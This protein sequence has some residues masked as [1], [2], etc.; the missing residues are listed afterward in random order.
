MV[1]EL[2][3][4]SHE[5]Q[6]DEAVLRRLTGWALRFSPLV[7][8]VAP[9]TLLLDITGCQ[10]LFGGEENI[11]RQ[12]VAGLARHGFHARAAIA[13]TIG[14][15]YA[16]ASAGRELLPVVPAGQA[17][18]YLAPLPPHTLRIEPQ[19]S[20]RLEALGVRS[21]GDLLMLPRATL[22]AR[23]GPQLVLRLQQ[24][25]G[26]V[27]ERVTPYH[28]AEIPF[29]RQP[30]EEPVTDGPA[31]AAAAQRLLGEVFDQVLRRETAL[32]RLECILYY[33]RTPPRAI[34]ISLSRAS[35]EQRHVAT[36][37]NQRLEQIDPDLG[38]T[39]LMLIA[40]ETARW[41]G[42]QGDLFERHDP[43]DDEAF[44]TLVDRIA[45]R[46]GYEAVLR[47]HLIADHQP[48]MA[49]R[50]VSIAETGCEAEPVAEAAGT[51]EPTP[52]VR[53]ARL[54]P[55]PIPIRVIA[56]VPDGPPT[57]FLYHGHEYAVAHAAG[58]ERLET[59]WWRGPDVRRDYFRVTAETG[60]QFWVFHAATDR[61]W[62]MH[63]VFA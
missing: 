40:R 63:G 7:E 28:P 6:R 11:A 58:P 60:E 19:V 47:P 8:P 27:F 24:A 45:G 49:C 36:L 55:R 23:F 56:L 33:E 17:S 59:A 54:L 5:P 10:L 53:P 14:A 57:W 29:V 20:E 62:Y 21:I 51:A 44:G 13:D 48:E 25:L 42:G 52:S 16:L 18:A 12:A 61:L 38:V 30:F 9:D 46:L 1:P 22:P 26:E 31:I 32:R 34:S 41:H 50:Y 43:G 35:R 2:V 3:V 4:L 15:A 37:L 39:G